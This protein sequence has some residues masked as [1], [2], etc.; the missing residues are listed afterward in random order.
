[1][2]QI[3]NDQLNVNQR[4]DY[5]FRITDRLFAFF[6]PLHEKETEFRSLL[7][8]LIML[9]PIDI[10]EKCNCTFISPLPLCRTLLIYF[11][12]IYKKK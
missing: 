1:M 8:G 2:T 6:D 3:L 7:I 11:R 5:A 9:S 12:Q 10:F 4:R